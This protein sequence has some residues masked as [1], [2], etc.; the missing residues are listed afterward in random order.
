MADTTLPRFRSM[1]HCTS[2]I[3]KMSAISSLLA[4]FHTTN[5]FPSNLK[6]SSANE[7]EKLGVSRPEVASNEA[8]CVVKG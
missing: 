6:W 2:S 5:Y 1:S 3:Q 4:T 8:P 7:L